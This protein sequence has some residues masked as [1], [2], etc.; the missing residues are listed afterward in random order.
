MSA[1]SPPALDEIG[2]M[3][4]HELWMAFVRD[5]DGNVVGMMNEVRE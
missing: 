4:D 2:Q 5:M 1:S 3:P